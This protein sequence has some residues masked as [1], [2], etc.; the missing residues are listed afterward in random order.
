[1]SKIFN[2]KIG[3][4]PFD[5]TKSSIET[6]LPQTVPQLLIQGHVAC[7][8][9]VVFD[10]IFGKAVSKHLDKEYE[11]F[12][13][14]ELVQSRNFSVKN[15]LKLIQGFC[16]LLSSRAFTIHLNNSLIANENGWSK[17]PNI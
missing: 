14:L 15:C 17:N 13:N 7:S 8:L 9:T 4:S 16:I 12:S 1:M 3:P 2:L 11:S 10:S 6:I 5:S